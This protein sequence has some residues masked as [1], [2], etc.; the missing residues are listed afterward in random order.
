MFPALILLILLL[1]IFPF[2]LSNFRVIFFP[3]EKVHLNYLKKNIHISDSDVIYDLGCGDGRVLKYLMSDSKA[4][5]VGIELSP[6]LYLISKFRLRKFKNIN[7]VLGDFLKADLEEASLA[8]CFLNK[9]ILE[10]IIPKLRAELKPGAKIISYITET[11]NLRRMSIIK[12]STGQD[13]F[14]IYAI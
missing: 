11:E 3:T 1:S 12:D 6:I 14:F 13:L 8:Y 7:I 9:K 5:G 4:R 2:L 10:K